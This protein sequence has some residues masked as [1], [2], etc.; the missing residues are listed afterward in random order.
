MRVCLRTFFHVCERAHV[1]RAQKRKCEEGV[2]VVADNSKTDDKESASQNEVLTFFLNLCVFHY[3][4]SLAQPAS[5]RAKREDSVEC[6]ESNSV[7]RHGET[8][9]KGKREDDGG[10]VVNGEGEPERSDEGE[11]MTRKTNKPLTEVKLV[12]PLYSLPHSSLSLTHSLSLSLSLTHAQPPKR[13][14]DCRQF[15]DDSSLKVFIGDPENAVSSYLTP[16][17]P[18]NDC[19]TL[20]SL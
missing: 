7:E 2:K 6:E 12:V 16:Q 20:L 4:I 15:L 5:K 9:G 10:V 18:L 14:I 17:P 8:E 3:I 19:P 11:V 1:S 13:C